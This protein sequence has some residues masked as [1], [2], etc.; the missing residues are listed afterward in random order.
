ML[1]SNP[2]RKAR[3]PALA[4][5]LLTACLAAAGCGGEEGAAGGYSQ[6]FEAPPGAAAVK[7]DPNANLSRV[8]QRRKDIEES[9]KQPSGK[10]GRRR[11]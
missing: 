5:A 4:T 11:S 3:R 1:I 7:P 8:E 6:N 2:A 10:G 9:R